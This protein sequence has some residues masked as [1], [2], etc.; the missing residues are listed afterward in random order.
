MLPR[1]F[2]AVV[3]DPS[4][5]FS[6]RDLSYTLRFCYDSDSYYEADTEFLFNPYGPRV[7]DPEDP[8][9][10]E[11]KYALQVTNNICLEEVQM[12]EFVFF[13]EGIT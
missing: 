7:E 11:T 3:F 9:V 2:G 4:Q 1:L 5:S 6:D 12:I 13:C 8:E 10:E